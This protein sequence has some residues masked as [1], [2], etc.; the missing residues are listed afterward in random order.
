MPHFLDPRALLEE[1]GRRW[2]SDVEG[3]RSVGEGR[4]HLDETRRGIRV[5][6]RVGFRVRGGGAYRSKTMTD[7]ETDQA[8][9]WFQE[10]VAFLL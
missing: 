5:T 10:D 2:C 1:V 8:A 7:Q 9:E 3:E 6:I 4:Q